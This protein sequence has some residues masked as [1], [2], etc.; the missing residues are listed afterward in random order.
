MA[1]ENTADSTDK[2]C[3]LMVDDSRVMRKAI[4]KILREEAELIEAVDGEDGWEKLL[5]HHEAHVLITD[6]E[7]P[8]L[9]GYAL[10]RRIRASEDARIRNIP[11]ITITGAEDEETKARAFACGATDFVTKPLDAVQLR[12]RVRV[13]ARLDET[14][15]QLAETTASLQQEA[16]SD[17]LTGLTSRRYFLQ[18]GAQDLAQA[19]RHKHDLAVIRLDIDDFKKLYRRHGDTIAERMLVWVAKLLAATAR[20]DDT[21]ARVGG[22]EFAI[23]APLTG[24]IEARVLGERLRSA[25]ETRPYGDKTMT[26]PL[27]ISAGAANYRAG[28][29]ETLE[30]LLEHAEQRLR[31]AKADGGNRVSTS[32]RKESIPVPE[33]VTL[34]IPPPPESA[35]SAGQSAAPERR[36]VAAHSGKPRAAQKK[37][38][39]TG[40]SPAGPAAPAEMTDINAA[41]TLLANGQ[42]E[43]LAPHAL[44]LIQRILPLLEYCDRELLLGL[45]QQIDAIKQKMSN[46]KRS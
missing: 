44:A 19:D 12:A 11:I 30:Q 34:D 6:I 15:R 21:V 18:R 32:A 9:D 39:Q 40:K 26:I 28:Q 27:T 36:S 14:T 35:P 10:I 37:P 41:L 46:A 2:A 42:A 25:V 5:R 45:Q 38:L 43:K 16:T 1:A 7:M 29:G 23:L 17:P 8:R 31:D 33:E 3:V 20:R 24:E 22:A 13:H 4:Q